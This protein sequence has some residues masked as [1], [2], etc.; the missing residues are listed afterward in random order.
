ME[1]RRDSSGLHLSQRKYIHDLL[2]R[3]NMLNAKPV[4]TP[5]ASSPKLSLHS[6]TRLFDPTEFRAI[7][8]SLQYLAFTRPNL[9]YAVSRLSQYMHAPTTEHWQAVKILL[10]YLVGTSDHGIMLCKGNNSTI[11]AYSDADWGGDKDDYI[12][13]NGYIVYLGSHPLSWSSKKQKGV[14]RSS[15]EA[16]YM[17]VANTAAE[18]Q[19]ICSLFTELGIQVQIPRVIYCDNVGATYLCANPVFHSRMKHTIDYHFIRNLVQSGALRVVH[20][21]TH[22]QLADVLTKPLSLSAF[23][24]FSSKIGVTRSPHLEGA[25]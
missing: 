1:T 24:N 3:T 8:G 20:I 17:Y 5:M 18:I 14:A 25:Y 15:I 19:W 16:E 7:I 13:I 11:Y 4:T 9:S 23:H 2:A 10:R 6:G 12:S 22:D 21:S